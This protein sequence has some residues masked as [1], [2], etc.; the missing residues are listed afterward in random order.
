MQISN[1]AYQDLARLIYD[2]FGIALGDDKQVLVTTR[3]LPIMQQQ[4]FRSFEEYYNYLAQ[5]RTGKALLTLANQITTNY[6]FFYREGEHFDFLREFALPQ[7]ITQPPSLNAPNL[8]I[9]SAGCSSGEEAYTLAMVLEDF[10]QTSS[11]RWDIGILATDIDTNMLNQASQAIY[12][13]DR[14]RN[15]PPMMR[16]RYFQ[17]V[18]A[19]QWQIK[20]DIKKYVHFSRFNLIQPQ[21]NFKGKFFAIFCRN[22]MIYFD[23]PR[24][25]KLIQNFYDVTEE[26][27]YLFIGQTESLDKEDCPYQYVAPAIYQKREVTRTVQQPEISGTSD[28]THLFEMP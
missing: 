15:I 4:G 1:Q 3:L 6:S 5:D 2:K 24:V 10:F 12:P 27:G 8:H 20:P 18:S 21:F 16:M 26:Q 23:K 28:K 11:S 14:L 19:H 13:E 22:V 7:K 25:K 17:S 9:W